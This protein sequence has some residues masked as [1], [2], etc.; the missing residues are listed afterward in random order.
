M[1]NTVMTDESY[2]DETVRLLRKLAADG[3][4]TFFDDWRVDELIGR[5]SYGQ[6]Y[7]ISPLSSPP[8][9]MPSALK[10]I[11]FFSNDSNFAKEIS[12]LRSIE[13]RNVVHIEDFAV[14]HCNDGGGYTL[15][16]M[17]LLRPVNVTKL[18]ISE[19]V[20]LG[21]QICAALSLCHK[22]GIIHRDIKP[23]NIMVSLGGDYKLTDFGLSRLVDDKAMTAVGTPHFMAPEVTAYRK[24]DHRADNY[25]LGLT[26]YVFANRGQKPFMERGD[27]DA[28]RRRL[29]GEP[30][31]PIPGYPQSFM[32]VL[33]RATAIDQERR[34]INMDVFSE[35]LALCENSSD[36][37]RLAKHLPQPIPQQMPLKP[38]MKPKPVVPNNVHQ[39]KPQKTSNTAVIVLGVLL[40]IA[41]AVAVLLGAVRLC[42]SPEGSSVYT[43]GGE[44]PK[45]PGYSEYDGLWDDIQDEPQEIFL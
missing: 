20:K 27:E 34:F 28:I 26:L 11:R 33:R 12:L 24:Y 15:I 43:H 40:A 10:V 6:V 14:M 36:Y 41:I 17:E 23:A 4:H 37:Y 5:G 2:S 18:D 29:S 13:S 31:P 1:N 19:V 30:L 9:S 35:A 16:K 8:L 39:P 42:S 3:Q 22:M 44:N 38:I 25:S 21:R 7:R 32:D 45:P